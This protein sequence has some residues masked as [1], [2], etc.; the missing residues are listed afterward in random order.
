MFAFFRK[1]PQPKPNGPREVDE[2]LLYVVG[3]VAL[4]LVA[5]AD[6]RIGQREKD[7]MVGL[8]RRGGGRRHHPAELLT[9]L[10]THVN[11]VLS[12]PSSVWPTFF[13]QGR[14]L[15][16]ELKELILSGCAKMAF[17]DGR[18]QDVERRLIDTI[19][20]SMGLSEQ[21]LRV[22][23]R[24]ERASLDVAIANGTQADGLGD[25]GQS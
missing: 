24:R 11:L 12:G 2:K 22:W 7:M 5:M 15:P 23:K 18:L 25:W 1:R 3:I 17:A 16:L 4:T 13:D 9:H 21:E 10:Q 20:L 8:L 19:A 14:S 6:G